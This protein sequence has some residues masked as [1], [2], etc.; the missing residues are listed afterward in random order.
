MGVYPC[1]RDG[2]RLITTW[3]NRGIRSQHARIRRAKETYL[4]KLRLMGGVILL[5]ETK[6]TK[7]EI[8][9]LAHH[10]KLNVEAW[11][12]DHTNAHSGGVAILTP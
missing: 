4:K 1:G 5:Q 12:G 3:N 8:G 11:V 2:G 6:C 7:A 9:D 10:L